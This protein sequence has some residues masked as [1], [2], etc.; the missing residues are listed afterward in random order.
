MSI[1]INMHE[2]NKNHKNL[3]LQKCCIFKTKSYSPKLSTARLTNDIILLGIDEIRLL[4]G[5]KPFFEDKTNNEHYHPQKENG[6][7]K[8]PFFN[9]IC[10]IPI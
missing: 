6:S 10:I 1:M 2:E 9:Q 3:F 4:P 8:N 5:E 7:L